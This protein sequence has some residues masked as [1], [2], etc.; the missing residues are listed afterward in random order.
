MRY[1]KT[2][3]IFLI[4]LILLNV[5][6]I[7]ATNTNNNN[8]SNFFRIHVV[9]N[10]D[11]IN[12]QLLKYEVAK[13]LEEYIFKLTADSN[14]KQESKEIIETNIQNILNLCNDILIEQGYS[15]DIK[16]Y[17]GRIEYDEKQKDN[18]HMSS[19]IYDSLKIVIGNGNGTNWWSLI[20]PT[21]D[22]DYLENPEINHIEY[23]LYIVELFK[24]IFYTEI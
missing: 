16:A 9:A 17:I 12:D 19:G 14:S 8:I 20:Y 22:Y 15:Y 5:S 3:I 18:I 6:I 1:K 7:F 2:F 13:E 11:S 4:A 10:S 21:L 24:K 23:K